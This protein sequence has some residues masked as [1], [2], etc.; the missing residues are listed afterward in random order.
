MGAISN[1]IFA[2]YDAMNQVVGTAPRG[3]VHAKGLYH[4]AVHVVV[5]NDRGALLVQRRSPHKDVCPGLWDVSVG[6]HLQPGET[7]EQGAK[8]GLNE[9]LGIAGVALQRLRPPRLQRFAAPEQNIL[10]CE[11]V[12]LWQTQYSGELTLQANEVSDTRHVEVGI[13][14]QQLRRDPAQYTPWLRDELLFLV[15]ASQS[16]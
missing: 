5:F 4:R 15:G 2:V 3:A 8:R 6:E 9:E 12:E 10:D 14:H 11:F 1:E 13:L 7:Y 16:G